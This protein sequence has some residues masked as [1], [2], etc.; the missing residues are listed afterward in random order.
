MICRQ[1]PSG[2]RVRFADSPLVGFG[3]K[4]VDHPNRY[5]NVTVE[6]TCDGW[7]ERWGG[8][9]VGDLLVATRQELEECPS[10]S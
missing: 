8:Y 10:A 4:V 5:G 7:R 2:T 9:K 1:L 3:A 6:L